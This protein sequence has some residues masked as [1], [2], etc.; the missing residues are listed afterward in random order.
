MEPLQKELLE[1]LLELCDRDLYQPL[2]NAYLTLTSYV[3]RLLQIDVQEL[4]TARATSTAMFQVPAIF[5]TIAQQGDAL[6]RQVYVTLQ[7]LDRSMQAMARCADSPS[8]LAGMGRTWLTLADKVQEREEIATRLAHYFLNRT[9]ADWVCYW[10]LSFSEGAEE[11]DSSAAAIA[12]CGLLELAGHLPVADGRRRLYE[13]AAAHIG[14][15]LASAY[16]AEGR[17]GANGLL[18]HAVYSKPASEGVDESCIW[19]DYF[20]ME[21]LARLRLSWKPY[22]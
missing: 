3:D 22:W 11:R 17:D 4:V 12:A 20:Y 14:A 5:D 10:D 1:R 16:F 6:Q 19:G 18:R 13:H 21:L 9:P 15:S 2:S 7:G 8:K